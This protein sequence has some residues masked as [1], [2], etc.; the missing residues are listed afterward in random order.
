MKELEKDFE[1]VID[2]SDIF[3]YPTISDMSNYIKG[4]AERKSTSVHEQENVHE[5][6]HNTVHET[7]SEND[8]D[9]ILGRMARGEISAAEAD[10]L[11]GLG[12]I[13]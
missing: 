9:A 10:K 7:G 5:T 13:K 1:G 2:I 11:L 12:E 4:K 3:T 8:I 6:V